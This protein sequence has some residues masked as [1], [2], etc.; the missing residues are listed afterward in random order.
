MPYKDRELYLIARV[1]DLLRDL[2]PVERG[3]I[4]DYLISRCESLGMAAPSPER[5]RDTADLFTVTSDS[6]PLD[7]YVPA[8]GDPVAGPSAEDG[9]N[10]PDDPEGRPRSSRAGAAGAPSGVP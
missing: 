2:Q 8:R 6:E 3:R 1:L 5:P 10:E 7:G 9:W 4:V